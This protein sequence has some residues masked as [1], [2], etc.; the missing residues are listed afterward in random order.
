MHNCTSEWKTLIQ[1]FCNSCLFI[2]SNIKCFCNWVITNVFVC[3]KGLFYCKIVQTND[4]EIITE[5]H[6]ITN[7][8]S[9]NSFLDLLCETDQQR[10]LLIK[11]YFICYLFCI[12]LHRGC[13]RLWCR[14]KG[15]SLFCISCRGSVQLLKILRQ[16]ESGSFP[17]H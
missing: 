14:V 3:L 5:S 10:M 16:K 1:I 9:A 7:N 12:I 17:A 8:C 6:K 13:S 11:A 4:A 15:R 2:H